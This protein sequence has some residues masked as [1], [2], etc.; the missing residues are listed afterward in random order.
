MA[1][2][3]RNSLAEEVIASPPCRDGASPVPTRPWARMLARWMVFTGE[4]RR[5]RIPSMC[6]RQLGSVETRNSAPAASALPALASPM[7]AEIMWN[8]T[9]NAQN[10]SNLRCRA[11]PPVRAPAP[12]AKVLAVPVSNL[13]RARSGRH[14]ERR[15]DGKA[16]A[17]VGAP[18]HLHQEFGKLKH[19]PAQ[20][21]SFVVNRCPR[22]QLRIEIAD[23]G[24]RLSWRDTPPIRIPE[25]PAQ[26]VP[27][28][29]PRVIPVASVEGPAGHSRFA[30]ADSRTRIPRAAA[31]RPYPGRFPGST[32]PQSTG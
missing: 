26:S 14:R 1:A 6:I 25:R 29:A 22:Q 21:Y 30:L 23:H 3:R 31:P 27:P 8:L 13:V 7:A 12:A 5:R 15:P 24:C 18:R 17:K 2:L 19:P 10:R 9:A 4:F 28:A 20:R 16:R 11:F 32:G